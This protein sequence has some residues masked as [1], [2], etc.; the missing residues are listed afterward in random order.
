MELTEIS[1]TTGNEWLYFKQNLLV[2]ITELLVFDDLFL[3][4][5]SASPMGTGSPRPRFV[6]FAYH[7]SAEVRIEAETRVLMLIMAAFFFYSSDIL[8]YLV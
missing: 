5:I 3:W 4:G 7:N 2:L 8:V 6:S 1:I